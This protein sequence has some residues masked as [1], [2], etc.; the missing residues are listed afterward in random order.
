MHHGLKG[1]ISTSAGTHRYVC[2]FVETLDT[3]HTV[4]IY[5]GGVEWC[6]E[7]SQPGN[8]EDG[9]KEQ[10]SEYATLLWRYVTV[11]STPL[12]DSDYGKPIVNRH[13]LSDYQWS[14]HISQLCR[15]A[16]FFTILSW[17]MMV[18]EWVHID[19]LMVNI[20]WNGF[21]PFSFTATMKNIVANLMIL[22][23]AMCIMYNNSTKLFGCETSPISC[24]VRS[25]VS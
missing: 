20:I 18:V 2:S 12:I 8:K 5:C 3:L 23:I 25:S 19:R 24:N 6:N 7:S 13:P 21:K 17:L 10:L 15:L 11:T 9:E 1:Y 16:Q 22:L 4:N 14:S